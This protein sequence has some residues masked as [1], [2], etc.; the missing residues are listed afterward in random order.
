MIMNSQHRLQTSVAFLAILLCATAAFADFEIATEEGI[1]Y[2][3]ADNQHLKLDMRRPVGDGPFP[4]VVCIHGGGFR[5]GDLSEFA[6]LC[7]KLAAKGYVAVTITYRLAPKYPYPAAIHDCKAAVRWLRANAK[8]YNIDPNRIGATGASAGGNLAMFLGVTGDQ[9]QFEGEGGNADQPSRVQCVVSFFGP[10]DLTRQYGNADA[11]Y[12][13]PEYL[14]GDLEKARD[15]HMQ[16]SPL[17][18][19]SKKDAP[20]LCIHGTKDEYVPL[21]QSEWIVEQLKSVEVPAELLVFE[22]A[23]HGFEGDTYEQADAAAIA[24]FNKHLKTESERQRDA[25]PPA[26]Q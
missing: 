12:T 24:F 15:K 4:A 16:A 2:S 11:D 14:G 23:G 19:V 17:T 18:W 25:A 3:N 8:K 22:G 21:Q 1:E 26:E 9:K 6:Y 7:D 20:T 5:E 13:L 10:S